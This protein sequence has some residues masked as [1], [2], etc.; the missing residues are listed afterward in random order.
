MRFGSSLFAVGDVFVSLRQSRF[1]LKPEVGIRRLMPTMGYRIK[2]ICG[3]NN[4]APT[5]SSEEPAI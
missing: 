3:K 1:L 5:E 2:P 4:E